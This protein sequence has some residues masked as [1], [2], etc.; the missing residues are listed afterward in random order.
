MTLLKAK[1]PPIFVV[2]TKAPI[3]NRRKAATFLAAI[4]LF[5]DTDIIS[6]PSKSREE[7]I[8]VTGWDKF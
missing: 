1:A 8:V 2:V 7:R 6:S 4:L 3:P 5:E